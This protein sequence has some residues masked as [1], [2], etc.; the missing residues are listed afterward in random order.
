MWRVFVAFATHRFLLFAVALIAINQGMRNRHPSQILPRFESFAVLK[1]EF[2]TRVS[3][4]PEVQAL[5]RLEP[6]PLRSL[7]RETKSPFLWIAHFVSKATH[8]SPILV[9]II[10]SN[11]FLL[12]FFSEIYALLNRM[13]TSDIAAATPLL[14]LLWPTSYELSLG[15]SLALSCYLLTL[16]IRHAMDDQ[17]ILVGLAT[18][19]LALTESV[20]LGLL[21]LLF[22]I[23]WFFQRA[24]PTN[25]MLRRLA[26]FLIP[27]LLGMVFGFRGYATQASLSNSALATLMH[28]HDWSKFADRA[29]AGQ[30]VT[31]VIFTAGAVGAALTNTVLLHRLIPVYVLGLLFLFSPLD[32]I[33]SRAPLAG[34]CLEGIASMSAGPVLRL[35]Q[36]MLLALGVY[37]VSIVFG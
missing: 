29:M 24:Y 7:F 2:L 32:S 23:F 8:F 15:S 31:A 6:A 36:F 10:L 14:V 5:R 20:A 12:L 37:E 9:L 22:Y 1:H 28:H 13:V 17:W 3:D 26:F 18:G 21:P 35:V 4:V 30:A 19:L 11:L 27:T 16:A 34:L 25:R 33:A